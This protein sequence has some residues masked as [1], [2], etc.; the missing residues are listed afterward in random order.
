MP[1]RLRPEN[2]IIMPSIGPKLRFVHVQ[3]LGGGWNS[4]ISHRANQLKFFALVTRYYFGPS[5]HLVAKP[6]TDPN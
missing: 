4:N 1:R 5:F 6:P 2:Y 3:S